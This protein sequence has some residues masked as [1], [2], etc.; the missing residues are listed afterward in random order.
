MFCNTYDN[1]VD[2]VLLSYAIVIIN[3]QERE[4]PGW[5]WGASV[6]AARTEAYIRGAPRW[7]QT[8]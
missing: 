1:V 7:L 6:L 5:S 4:V 8:L 3:T 2:K